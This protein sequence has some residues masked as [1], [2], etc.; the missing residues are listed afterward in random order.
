MKR[1]DLLGSTMAAVLAQSGTSA[2]AADGPI[3]IVI[4]LP[5]GGSIDVLAR[6]VADVL[7]SALARPVMV[8][9]K[10]GASGRIAVEQVNAAARDGNTLLVCPQGPMTLFPHVFKNLRYDPARDFAP[11]ARIGVSEMAL[12][13]GPLVPARDLAGVREWLRTAGE[14]ASFGSPGAGSIPHFAGVAVAEKLGVKITHVPY[15]GAARAMVDLAG[16]TLAAVLSPVTEAAEMHKAGRIQIVATLGPARSS[17]LP[18]VPNLRELGYDLVVQAWIA[19]YGPS[20]LP[21]DVTERLHAA[22]ANGLTTPESRQRMTAQGVMPAVAGPAEL[23]ALR[24]QESDMWE[25]I[26]RS[27]GFVP[28]S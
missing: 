15:Q 9:N 22:L 5:P 13:V 21:A 17:F 14:R 10:P 25:R 23:D 4:G 16:G 19:C 28:E 8:E 12:S 18:Q 24:R 27:T 26:V 7:A 11:I 3:R 20:G 6:L 2:G 1:R